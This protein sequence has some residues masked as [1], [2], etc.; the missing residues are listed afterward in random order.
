[1]GFILTIYFILEATHAYRWFLSFFPHER[2]E[3]P[4]QSSAAGGDSHGQMAA[5][6]GA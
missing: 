3:R 4:R 5:W 2:R 6:Q 1:M